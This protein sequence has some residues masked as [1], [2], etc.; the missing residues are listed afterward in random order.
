MATGALDANGVWIYGEDDSETTFSGLLNK[1]GNSVTGTLKGRILQVV[2]ASTTTAVTNNTTTR[3]DTTL[4][5]TITPKSAS[6]KI[7]VL[8]SLGDINTATTTNV[9]ANF[10][11]MRGA[12]DLFAF[13]QL[14][15]FVWNAAQFSVTPGP[16]VNY[17]DVPGTTS[18][19]TYKVQFANSVN[20]ATM[21]IHNYGSRSTITLIEVS[22]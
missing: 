21:R 14:T 6:S 12:T 4:T 18:P 11:L 8:V 10:W 9:A 15:G 19:T 7:I 1:L 16:S 5:A 20:A 22:Q 17:V 3:V 13:G 2:N